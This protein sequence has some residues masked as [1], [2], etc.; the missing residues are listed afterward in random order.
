MIDF[1]DETSERQGTPI[2]RKN[3]MAVQGFEENTITYG[4]GRITINHAT[5][6]STTYSNMSANGYTVT[7][8]DEKEITKTVVCAKQS[9]EVLS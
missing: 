7:F 3:L 9:T 2:N 5:G 8:D 6:G 4:N 1:I